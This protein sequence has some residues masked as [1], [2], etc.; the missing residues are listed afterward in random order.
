MIDKEDVALVS[1]ITGIALSIASATIM[2]IR[3]F[4]AVTNTLVVYVLLI[5][6]A[7]LV[8]IG[9]LMTIHLNQPGDFANQQKRHEAMYDAVTIGVVMLLFVIFYVLPFVQKHTALLS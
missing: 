4:E 6:A 1:R 3:P 8:M 2:F 7:I 9:Q 5:C